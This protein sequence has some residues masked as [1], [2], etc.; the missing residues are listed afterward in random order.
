MLATY[1]DLLVAE[2]IR[3]VTH[4]VSSPES[5][6]R[7]APPEDAHVEVNNHPSHPAAR[8]RRGTFERSSDV[9]RIRRLGPRPEAYI[10]AR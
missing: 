10:A 6:L 2:Q 9:T 4:L 3:E 5:L 7:P 1:L 8:T